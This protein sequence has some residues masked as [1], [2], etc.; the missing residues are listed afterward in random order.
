MRG[1]GGGGGQG[2]GLG[3]GRSERRANKRYG[4]VDGDAQAESELPELTFRQLLTILFPFFWPQGIEPKIYSALTWLC[5]AFSKIFSLL[6]PL[7]IADATN[8]VV[9][10]QYVNAVKEVTV[11]C[12][13]RF[14]SAVLKESQTLIFSRVKQHAFIQLSVQVSRKERKLFDAF[15]F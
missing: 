9:Q 13:L 8:S 15:L 11:F 3:L 5:V 10:G 12:I 7:Y 14:L 4:K 2:L 1:G 6:S